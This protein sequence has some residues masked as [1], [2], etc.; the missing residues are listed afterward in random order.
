MM[1]GS[2]SWRRG[3][4]GALL[5]VHVLVVCGGCAR[6]VPQ[7]LVPQA[8][9]EQDHPGRLRV[10]RIDSSRVE[11]REPRVERDS[12]KGM[13]GHETRSVPLTDVAYVSLRRQNDLPVILG[14]SLG[15][16]VGLT[17]LLSATWDQ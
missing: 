1:A 12:L 17:V 6:W 10:T 3:G 13:A 16:A 8:V 4:A 2:P 5:A 9:I 15:L 11:L 14:V 7:P